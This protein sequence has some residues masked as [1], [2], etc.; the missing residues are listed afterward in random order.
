MEIRQGVGG[1][2][3][4]LFVDQLLKMCERFALKMRWS[5]ET[6]CLTPAF[7]GG[8]KQASNLI[9]GEGSNLWLKHEA[10]VHRVQRVLRT[11]TR[12]S[13]QTSTAAVASC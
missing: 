9:A 12:G 1:P 6:I 10:G 4:S 2:E 5:A 8:V 7:G 3:A 11:E 13:V